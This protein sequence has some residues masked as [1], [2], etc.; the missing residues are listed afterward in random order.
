MAGVFCLKM[1]LQTTWSHFV[2]PYYT[3][4]YHL[5]IY[6][7]IHI[8]NLYI[9]TVMPSLFSIYF[10]SMQLSIQFAAR[11]S[12]PPY[13][14]FTPHKAPQFKN[15]GSRSTRLYFNVRS[16][17]LI[18]Q[19]LRNVMKVIFLSQ[20]FFCKT[21]LFACKIFKSQL[22]L[23]LKN[24]LR[25][26]KIFTLNIRYISLSAGMMQNHDSGNREKI[27]TKLYRLHKITCLPRQGSQEQVG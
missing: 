18:I 16:F 7:G 5:T 25:Q 22:H 27:Q 14:P 24:K 6:C 10:I 26:K 9:I 17:S 13:E 8:T 4:L 15:L 19:N 11:C 23:K 20:N 1:M 21:N 12:R 3:L 2:I